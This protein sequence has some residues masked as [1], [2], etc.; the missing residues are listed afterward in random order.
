M[1]NPF[2]D[3]RDWFYNE[4]TGQIQHIHGD[5]G[6]N[7]EWHLF[8]SLGYEIRFKTQLEAEAYKRAHPP[9][10]KS[11]LNPTN[12]TNPIHVPVPDIGVGGFLRALANSNTWLRVAEV[13]LGIVLIV[14]GLVKLAPPSVAK[15]MKTVGKVA[16]VL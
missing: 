9:S 15:N 10:H 5:G 2:Y 11:I 8:A 6:L 1:A 4:N 7:P 3:G 16:A 12:P 13:V 14:V